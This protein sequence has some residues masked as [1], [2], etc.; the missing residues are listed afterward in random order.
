[1]GVELLTARYRGRIAGVLCCYDR[2]IIQG[3]VPGWCCASGMT[4]YFYAHRIRI[5]DY[6]KWAEPLREAL[7]ENMER[8]AAGNAIDERLTR[9]AIHTVKPDN[10]AT[11][12]GRKL[13]GNDQDEMGNRFHTRIEGTRIQHSR[14]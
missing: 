8:I 6:P 4:G 2:I 5:F 7:G 10:M 3:T 14:G 9:T 1:M 12:P 13:N 11:F